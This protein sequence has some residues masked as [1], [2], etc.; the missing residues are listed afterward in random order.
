MLIHSMC[1]YLFKH[2]I[3]YF[4][5]S[6]S[7]SVNLFHDHLQNRLSSK[8]EFS[9]FSIPTSRFKVVDGGGDDE[10]DDGTFGWW[11]G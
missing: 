9:L 2:S 11:R 3:P 1:N 7:I 10:G 8:I 4:P 6:N 5:P